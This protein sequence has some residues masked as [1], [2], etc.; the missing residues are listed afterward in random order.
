MSDVILKA[1]DLKKY[2]KIKGRKV[3][4]AVDGVSIEVERGKTLGLVG[5]SGCGKSTLGR[6][7]IRIYEP[8]EGKITLN[9]KDISGKSTKR[10]RQDL[11]RSIQMIF[12]DPYACLSP[13]MTVS[14]LISEGWGLN[15][16]IHMSAEEKR[17][18]VIELLETVGL[19]EEHANRFPH[20]FSG[21]QR[22][23]I[24]I[25][26]ALSMSPELIICDEPIS[27]LDVSIQAQV[28]NL[29]LKLQQDKGLSYI[30]IAHDLSMVRY[31]SDTVAVMYLGSIME[32]ATNKELYENPQHPYTKALFS[33]IPVA[34]PKIEKGRSRIKLE[35]EIP[36]PINSPKG[37]KFCTRCA[38]AKP[39]CFEQPPVLK[40]CG[41]GHK[42][43][44]HLING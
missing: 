13:R 38:Y 41:P 7:L 11:A 34:N 33:A 4:K 9:G 19:N 14:Q 29:L 40:E 5:E 20:E 16:A 36:S 27:A 18:R 42:V 37:C 32:Y 31:I 25:A 35:G 8:T 3:V 24:G 43:A 17:D 6:T 30:F 15:H 10:F 39:V 22:Q 23:R 1:E 26:R 44:C 21:G 12:Q 28:V 2:F